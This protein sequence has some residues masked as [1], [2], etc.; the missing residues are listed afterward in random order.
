MRRSNK[1]TISLW[2]KEDVGC[3]EFAALNHDINA[4]VCVVGAGISGLTTAYFLQKHEGKSVVVI[5]SWTVGSGETGRTTAHL[6]YAYDDGYATLAKQFGNEDLRVIAGSHAAA[7]DQ[8]EAIVRD[9]HIDC[10]FER[11]DG[12]LT[13]M[14]PDQEERLEQ[15]ISAC[16]KAGLP[17][18]S[19]IPR[20]PLSQTNGGKALR[21]P[22]QATFN[23]ARYMAGLAAAFQKCGGQIF[24]K[25][26]A[27]E[28]HDGDHPY[29][30]TENK[31]RIDAASIIVATNT[32]VNDW[33][34]M[35]TKQAAYRSYVVAFKI[36]K[37]SYPGFLLWDLEEPYHYARLSRGDEEDYII[38]GGEDH[39][40]GQANDADER[41]NRL[42]AWSRAHFSGLGPIVC[43]WSGQ[44]MEPV[45]HLAFIGRNPGSKN[46]YIVTGD[47]GNGITHGTIA[48]MLI[49]D[50]VQGRENPWEKLYDPARISLK[51][52]GT[53]IK[54]NTNFV[55]CMVSDWAAPSEVD[56]VN[57]IRPGQGA[58]M[59]KGLSKV[60]IFKD[61]GGVVKECSA[62]CTHLG[63]VVQWN[64][65]EKSWDCPCHG[66][67]FDTDGKVLNGPA[68]KALGEAEDA[69][70]HPIAE[71]TFEKS[72]TL[73]S[74]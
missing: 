18:L 21:Y 66:S 59:R 32:P 43:R 62:V 13:A 20:I 53:Y 6:T 63:C 24:T 71:Q 28:I 67:R 26:R 29:V 10:D 25:T 50:L 64:A 72:R 56:D 8:I 7:I 55:G 17:N 4:D 68:I 51:S 44:I 69:T 60:A 54:E 1:E 16:E 47:S 39:K 33:V 31:N 19:R 61:E 73:P 9:E 57:E 12:Y 22:A 70:V 49:P 65:G 14:S 5:D 30:E 45:D 2:H 11:I 37:D 23:M 35:H 3:P 46:V 58:I 74:T 36:P 38:I 48:G 27:M 15:E 42:E 52:A 34:K 41:Y 40:V